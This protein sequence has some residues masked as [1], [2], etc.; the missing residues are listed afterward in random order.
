[1]KRTVWVVAL[2]VVVGLVAVLAWWLNRRESVPGELV[3]LWECR[4]A[5]GTAFF[6]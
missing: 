1:M 6:Q 4:P 2:V 5:A 3:A